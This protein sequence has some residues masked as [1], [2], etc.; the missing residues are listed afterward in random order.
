MGSGTS[1]DRV[2]ILAGAGQNLLGLLIF[3]VATLGTNVLISRA[4]GR[5]GPS[6]LGVITLA[7]QFAF[8][9]AAATRF[10]MDMAAVRR[11][12]IDVGRGE[13]GRARAVVIRAAAVAG[14][15][16]VVV[17][18]VVL[19]GAPQ[20]ARVFG[21]PDGVDA[22]RAAALALPFVALCQVYLGG[23]RGL[24]VMRHTLWIYWAGQPV[25]WI[26]VMLAAWAISRSVGSSV[27]AYSMS[28][29]AAT[30]AAAF[31]WRSETRR[32][33]PLAAEPGETRA[34]IGYG[35]PRAPAALLAQLLFWADYF[36]LSRYVSSAEL[37]IYAAAV[38]V[39]QAIVL[40][41]I[42]VNYMFS[43]YVADLHARGERDQ[44]DGLFKSLTRWVVAGTIPILLLLAI[45]PA[46]VLLVFGGQ[47]DQG[48]TALRILLIGQA[49]NVAVGS[50]GF[51]LIMVGRTGWD[52]I[53]YA[54][55]F[56]FD[57][58][59]AFVLAPRFGAEGAAIAQAATLAL[60]NLARLYLVWRF[61]RIQPF[62]RHYGRLAFPAAA[63]AL[64]M[65]VLQAVLRNNVWPVQ[66][67]V[68]AVAGV[69]VYAA[70]LFTVGLSSDERRAI[71]RFAG[72]AR[73]RAR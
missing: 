35:A 52:L 28:W 18:L 53:V 44:L 70:A 6:A 62:D 29:L 19:L 68:V 22:F 67:A 38:R 49:V 10:G 34:L 20:L 12:A 9:G 72:L 16:S 69:I 24:K 27:L 26:L 58:A 14:A 11:V 59:L 43:P 8:V 13:G 37:G 36:V 66:L 30:V 48:T 56:A 31:A 21:A 4:F 1:S 57:V 63:T 5:E 61:V 33:A 64:V 54:A 50:V 39:A 60:S 51:I 23:T 65:L 73:Q 41:L 45:V 42:A 47:F 25:V 55:S 2:R 32:F 7:T 3:V 71:A 17:G 40:F 46:P 15:V